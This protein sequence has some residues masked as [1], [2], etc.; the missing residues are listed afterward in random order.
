MPTEPLRALASD[1]AYLECW[2]RAA[3]TVALPW[4]ATEELLLKFVAHHL[5]DP[6]ERETDPSHGMP[7]A[8]ASRLRVDGVLR[9]DG[10]HAPTTVQRRL[11]NWSTL[12]RWKGLEGP[13]ASPSLKTATRLAV[14]AAARVRQRKSPMPATRDVLDRLLATCASGSL[15]DLRDRA[16]LLVGFGSGGRR[17]SELAGLRVERLQDEEPVPADPS[18]PA[19]ERLLCLSIQLG[20]TKTG[21]ADDDQRAVIVGRPVEAL[22]AWL[23]AAR[24]A[25]G[26]VFR[27]IDRW[28]NLDDRAITPQTVNTIVKRRAARAGINP[29]RISAHGLRSGYMTEAFEQGVPLPDAMRQSQHRSVQQAARYYDD[30]ARKSGRAARLV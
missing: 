30:A 5:W 13:F 29:A 3:T 8:V 18:N 25:K 24:I 22:K 19:S 21:A 16:I 1:L 14:R 27:G 2:C 7:E 20:R 17:R 11:A 10:P 4:P 12:H 15:V 9:A 28:G 26:P 6:A 23:A